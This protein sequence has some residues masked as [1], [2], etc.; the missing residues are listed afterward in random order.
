MLFMSAED[1][2]ESGLPLLDTAHITAHQDSISGCETSQ[3]PASPGGPRYSQ[4]QQVQR[5][6]CSMASVNDSLDARDEE[7]EVGAEG[8][9]EE[10]GQ[11]LQ[12]ELE[13]RICYDTDGKVLPLHLHKG[14]LVL[15]VCIPASSSILAGYEAVATEEVI[16]Q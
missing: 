16:G 1:V 8:R 5:H 4:S 3:Q 13:S 14:A 10:E 11:A 6:T 7:A 9:E 12:K 2:Q 15:S